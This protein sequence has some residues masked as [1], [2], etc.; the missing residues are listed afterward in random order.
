MSMYIA[1]CVVPVS[2]IWVQKDWT[3]VFYINFFVK[4]LGNWNTIKDQ[5]CK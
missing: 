2:I 5:E 1:T 4:K 3:S